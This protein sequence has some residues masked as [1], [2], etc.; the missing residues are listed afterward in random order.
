MK[1]LIHDKMYEGKSLKNSMQYFL[2]NHDESKVTKT[3]TVAIVAF[4]VIPISTSEIS[5][6]KNMI[7]KTL[8]ISSYVNVTLRY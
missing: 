4:K 6:L 3:I 2:D 1:K 7:R 5:D 8:S